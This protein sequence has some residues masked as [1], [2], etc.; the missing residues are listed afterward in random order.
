MGL[1]AGGMSWRAY[2][3]PPSTVR[4]SFL[5]M[6]VRSGWELGTI[7]NLPVVYNPVDFGEISDHGVRGLDVTTAKKK[8]RSWLP[9]YQE[10]TGP[11]TCASTGEGCKACRGSDMTWIRKRPVAL[12]FDPLDTVLLAAPLAPAR[13]LTWGYGD[14]GT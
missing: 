4:K 14:L 6:Y 2:N 5:H 3:V 11:H 1:R 10:G 7:Y 8:Q 13:T 12:F 9:V